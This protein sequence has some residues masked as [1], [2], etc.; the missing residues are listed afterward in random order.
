MSGPVKDLLEKFDQKCKQL[1]KDTNDLLAAS[2]ELVD[3]VNKEKDYNSKIVEKFKNYT[4]VNSDIVKLNVGGVPFS[5]FKST[6]TKRIKDPLSGNYFQPSIF[7]GMLNG[8][9]DTKYDENQAIFIDRNPKY[10]PFILDY[11]RNADSEFHFEMLP[12]SFDR[13]ELAKEAKYYNLQALISLK[14]FIG[15]DSSI[16]DAKLVDELY[17]TCQFATSQRWKL[18]YRASRDGFQVDSF[19]KKCDGILNVLTVVKSS[20]GNVFGGYSDVAWDKS[21]VNKIDNNAFIFSLTNFSKKAIKIECI[22]GQPAIYCV[23]TNGPVFGCSSIGYDLFISDNSNT[24]GTS[25]SSLGYMY[26]HPDYEKGTNEANT[27]LAG[28]NKF[29]VSEI[30]IFTKI[31]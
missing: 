20:N 14:A 25:S 1:E 13:S 26:K 22:N 3:E 2:K 12:D 24:G 18:L 21:G 29:V 7:E 9:T 11:L 16:L 28:S 19:H 31:Q 30:E 17:K 27:F 5:S 23:S 15:L 8:Y 10:F 4:P 6:L